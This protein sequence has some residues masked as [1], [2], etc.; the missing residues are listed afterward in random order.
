ME[1]KINK[2]IQ[3][4]TEGIFFG[5]NLRQLIFSALAVGA[6]VGVYFGLH[7]RLGTETVSWLCVLAA[8]PFALMAFF[9]YNGMTAEQL[10][11]A[12][13]KSEV[14]MPRKYPYKSHNLYYEMLTDYHNEKK[15]R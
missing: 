3:E 9:K 8:S 2:D 7:K 11:W 12:W 5:L 4:Y 13:L 15:D 14:I 1:I 6:A 10:A